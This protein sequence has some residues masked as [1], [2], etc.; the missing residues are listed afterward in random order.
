M[1]LIVELRAELLQ[2]T[3][4]YVFRD[5]CALGDLERYYRPLMNAAQPMDD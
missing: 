1:I 2:Y 5:G 3:F 4:D